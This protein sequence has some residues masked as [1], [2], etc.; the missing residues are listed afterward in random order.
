MKYSYKKVCEILAD[1]SDNPSLIEFLV[2]R[3]RARALVK[4]N[5]R[6]KRADGP[7]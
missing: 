5:K 6:R 3:K 7:R 1:M 4:A 2:L